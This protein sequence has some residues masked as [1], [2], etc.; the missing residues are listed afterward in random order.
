MFFL[1]KSESAPLITYLQIQ[2]THFNR[3]HTVDVNYEKI[4]LTADL[5]PFN[6][7]KTNYDIK[8]KWE[9]QAFFIYVCNWTSG[10]DLL[11]ATCN[12]KLTGHTN[13][14]KNA[15]ECKSEHLDQQWWYLYSSNTFYRICLSTMLLTV[16]KN[17]IWF[18]ENHWNYQSRL[19]VTLWQIYN[20]DPVHFPATHFLKSLF[21]K[22]IPK[23]CVTT[24][25]ATIVPE[26]DKI[27]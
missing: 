3:W 17:S 13:M 16:K 26:W 15:F 25:M 2:P 9:H 14:K 10:V 19:E 27:L 6:I 24:D 11:Y 20:K 4:L 1:S 22:I 18:S 5:D 21:R 8:C 23:S 12:L 7:K